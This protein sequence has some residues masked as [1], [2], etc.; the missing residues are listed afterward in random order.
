MGHRGVVHT[1]VL[2][3][4]VLTLD[5]LK[6]TLHGRTLQLIESRRRREDKFYKIETLFDKLI[7]L[8]RYSIIK[9]QIFKKEK[10]D[11]TSLASKLKLS[12][13]DIVSER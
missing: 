12:Y 8:C 2:R 9:I 11:P 7:P 13:C 5:Y 10:K 3:P 1:T 4:D 6:K